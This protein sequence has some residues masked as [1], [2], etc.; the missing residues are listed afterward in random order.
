MTIGLLGTSLAL[1]GSVVVLLPWLPQATRRLE[2]W[3]DVPQ[4]ADGRR[5]LVQSQSLRAGDEGFTVI[6]EL[7]IQ[8][9]ELN[10]EFVEIRH[11][12]GLGTTG[13]PMYVLTENEV[14]KRED[15]S[16]IVGTHVGDFALYN[17]QLM[18]EKNDRWQS[19][20][21]AFA[22]LALSLLAAGAALQV[23]AILP[24]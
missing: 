8:E 6:A 7:L 19:V 16:D 10:H 4:L 20:Q 23:V 15:E 17:P 24:V 11:H 3:K 13:A 9:H 18:Q 1:L 14:N 5:Q 12:P 2:E 22:S 21:R